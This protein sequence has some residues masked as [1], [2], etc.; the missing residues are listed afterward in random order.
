[1]FP[2]KYLIYFISGSILIASITVIA[3]KKSPKIAGIL[4]SLP[5][6]TFLSLI[7]MAMSQGVD[8][9][10]KAA[11][12]NPMGAVADLVYMGFFA[13]GIKFHEYIDKKQNGKYRSG[14]SD[15]IK[16]I[17]CGLILGFAGY[18]VSVL[19]LSK[20]CRIPV[21]WD[22]FIISRYNNPST[23]A[24]SFEERERNELQCY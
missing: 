9:A 8:F 20:F 18:L 24:S 17:F 6:I 15:R 12:W 4:M 16:E 5:V 7:F 1:M 14:S 10:S 21:G 3:E 13:A 19:F 2:L 11:I 23:C 22:F